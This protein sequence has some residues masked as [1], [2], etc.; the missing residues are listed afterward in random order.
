MPF[1][2]KKALFFV[3]GETEVEFY[4]KI[5][6]KYFLS[7]PKK[8]INLHGNS[9]IYRKILGETNE[10]LRRNENDIVRIYC[11]ID[12]ESRYHNPPLNINEL[13]TLLKDKFKKNFLSAE[14]IIA[15]QMIESWFFHDIEGIYKF[16]SVPKAER[17]PH[18]FTPVQKL[19]HI[20]LSSLFE[21]YGKL[22]IKGKKCKFFLDNIDLIK[23]YEESEE[24]QR[25]L[26]KIKK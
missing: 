16:L 3:E 6:S 17:K 5:L 24:L 4:N 7:L 11:C 26:K 13:I 9:N 2:K 8:I 21:R 10:H 23:I 25:G 14:Q 15:T 18:F 20:H 1:Q 22:Y 12:R 19:T